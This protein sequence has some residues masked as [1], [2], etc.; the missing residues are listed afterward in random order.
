MVHR[1]NNRVNKSLSLH[2]TT[3]T[4]QPV[5][6]VYHKIS[7]TIAAPQ[8]S[9]SAMLSP[10]PTKKTHHHYFTLKQNTRPF[11]GLTNSPNGSTGDLLRRLLARHPPETTIAVATPRTT[12]ISAPT[13]KWPAA[14]VCRLSVVSL[15]RPVRDWH[16]RHHL[17]HSLQ[18][19]RTPGAKSALSVTHCP[20][21]SRQ[22]AQ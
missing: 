21:S 20:Q 8:H 14:T 19:F 4:N 11:P 1:E 16:T 12:D 7:Q 9:P 5:H 2:S 10:E 6:R 17:D 3:P 13:D 18:Q 15:D 22:T